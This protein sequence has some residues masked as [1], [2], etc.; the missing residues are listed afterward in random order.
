VES[1]VVKRSGTRRR[2]QGEAKEKERTSDTHDKPNT[3]LREAAAATAVERLQRGLLRNAETGVRADD[4]Q[5]GRVGKQPNEG[6]RQ[7]RQ[8]RKTGETER[9]RNRG[10]HSQRQG[11]TRRRKPT[12]IHDE[13]RSGKAVGRRETKGICAL[14]RNDTGAAVVLPAGQSRR[15]A[16]QAPC[17]RTAPQSWPASP[18]RTLRSEDRHTT[19]RATSVKPVQN[20]KPSANAIRTGRKAA[21]VRIVRHVDVAQQ[22]RIGEQRL[23]D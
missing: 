11:D 10:G 12:T 5:N 22:R 6:K 4:Q 20:E 2:A 14:R 18:C 13:R 7:G 8:G 23:C 9:P 3:N 16:R 21:Q 19:T 15:A 17:C 1:G